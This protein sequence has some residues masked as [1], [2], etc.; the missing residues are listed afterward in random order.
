M[1]RACAV[2]TGRG[3]GSADRLP[4]PSASARR[5]AGSI[6]DTSVRRPARAAR[7]ATAAA[8]VVFPTPPG[9]AH[10]RMCLVW[11]SV[12]ITGPSP[13]A[14]QQGGHVVG[15]AGVVGGVQHGLARLL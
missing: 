4:S 9:P 10:T 2:S 6:V 7:M 13:D 14:H 1:P 3:R 8:V 12:R 5:G 15:S 11:T